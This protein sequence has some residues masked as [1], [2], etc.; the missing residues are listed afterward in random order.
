[1]YRPIILPHTIR[2]RRDNFIKE[3]CSFE[4]YIISYMPLPIRMSAD[5][6]FTLG[7][8]IVHTNINNDFPLT[9]LLLTRQAD[10]FS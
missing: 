4:A 3:F 2:D 1:M 7:I 5:S 6:V 9:F 8:Y 10:L